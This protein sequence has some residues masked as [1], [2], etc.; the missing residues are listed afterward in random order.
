[1][2]S[3]LAKLQRLIE[4]ELEHPSYCWD[5]ATSCHITSYDEQEEEHY[6][7]LVECTCPLCWL[8]G[9]PHALAPDE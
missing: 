8:I 7:E 2:S 5:S 3:L 6:V 9:M 1:M 4:W